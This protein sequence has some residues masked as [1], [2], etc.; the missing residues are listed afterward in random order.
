MTTTKH[1][2]KRQVILCM[3]SNPI[4]KNSPDIL[5]FYIYIGGDSSEHGKEVDFTVS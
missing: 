3:C 2:L 5:L 1:I 4:M